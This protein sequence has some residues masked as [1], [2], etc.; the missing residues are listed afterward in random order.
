MLYC[1]FPE[2]DTCKTLVV[3]FCRRFKITTFPLLFSIVGEFPSG[4]L[5]A[6]HLRFL[7]HNSLRFKMRLI[8]IIDWCPLKFM[9]LFELEVRE[10][11]LSGE[12]LYFYCLSLC[13]SQLLRSWGTGSEKN[14]IAWLVSQLTRSAIM[15]QGRT[16]IGHLVSQLSLS[17]KYG[18]G[19]AMGTSRVL[20]YISSVL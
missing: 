19:R 15:V 2:N 8:P 3:E 6:G 1:I 4:L 10:P 14:L 18:S 5:D 17:E 12:T 11:L 16:N 20:L 9:V 13:L 7:M